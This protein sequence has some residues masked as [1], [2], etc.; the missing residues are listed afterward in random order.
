[1][2]GKAITLA[3]AAIRENGSKL[4]YFLHSGHSAQCAPYVFFCFTGLR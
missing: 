3:T 4:A 2:Y 1:M